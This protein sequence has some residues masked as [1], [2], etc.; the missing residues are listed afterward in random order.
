[1]AK[2]A[3]LDNDRLKNDSEMSDDAD[4]QFFRRIL[5]NKSNTLHSYLHDKSRLQHNKIK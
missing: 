3:E 1:M 4:D 5:N 2:F